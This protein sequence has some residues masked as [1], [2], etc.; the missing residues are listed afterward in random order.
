MTPWTKEANERLLVLILNKYV[1][2]VDYAELAAEMDGFTAL[3]IR[4]QVSKLKGYKQPR[5][6]VKAKEKTKSTL[7][8]EVKREMKRDEVKEKRN[9]MSETVKREV[10]EEQ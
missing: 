7:K 9:D 2:S 6:R 4:H 8:K 10:K 3:A 1:G 5:N